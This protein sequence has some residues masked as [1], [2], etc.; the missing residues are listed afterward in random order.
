MS[1]LKSAVDRF[2]IALYRLPALELP[3]ML[4]MTLVSMPGKK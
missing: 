4:V 1:S 2:G 3:V